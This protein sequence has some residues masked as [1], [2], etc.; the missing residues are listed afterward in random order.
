MTEFWTVPR[1]WEGE[2]AYILAAGPSLYLVELERLRGRP[3]IAVNFSYLKAP[4]ADVIYATDGHFWPLVDD[5]QHQN[6]LK[7]SVAESEVPGVLRLENTGLSGFEESPSGLRIGWTSTYA[8]INLAVHF[9][10]ARIVLL[11]V[12]MRTVEGRTHWEGYPCAD[13]KMETDPDFYRK[14]LMPNFDTLVAPLK[15]RRVEVL[16]ATPGS[17]LHCFP[18]V[19]LKSIY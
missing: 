9:G 12:D 7:I 4:W 14:Y 8:A 5:R 13:P 18:L 6:S 16:N 3:T 11:G 10:A 17:A 15:A 2:T 1:T 19:P